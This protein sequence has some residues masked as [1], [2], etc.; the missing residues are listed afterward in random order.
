VPCFCMD[1]L[2]GCAV[3]RKMKSNCVLSD[4]FALEGHFQDVVRPK[5]GKRCQIRIC[6]DNLDKFG[7]KI[8]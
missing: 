3:S 2:D 6:S 1:I 8:M 4:P 7:S 5:R